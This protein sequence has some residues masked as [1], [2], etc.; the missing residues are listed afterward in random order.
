V[1]GDSCH[2]AQPAC[3][4]ARTDDVAPIRRYGERR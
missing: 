1:T 2:M 4:R 3:D